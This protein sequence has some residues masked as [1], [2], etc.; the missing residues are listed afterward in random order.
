MANNT[1][2]ALKSLFPHLKIKFSYTI[3]SKKCPEVY[4]NF[5]KLNNV[6]CARYTWP[7][8][9]AIYTKLCNNNKGYF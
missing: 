2:L 3:N 4:R 8:K 7:R 9:R 1:P 5:L 6:E